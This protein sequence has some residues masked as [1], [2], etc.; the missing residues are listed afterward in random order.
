MR[1][2]GIVGMLT[3]TVRT[4]AHSWPALLA[5]FL[6]GWTARLL[7]LRF[8]GWV[9]NDLPLLGQ[10]ILP[11]A[12]IARLASYVAM[13]LVLRDAL[14][15]AGQSDA[16]APRESFLRRWGTAISAAILPFFVIYAAWGMVA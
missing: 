15:N 8:A 16:A 5:W 2:S 3:T 14:P 7:I 6:A 1:E 11:L 10:L 9:G 13:F 4:L 12:V